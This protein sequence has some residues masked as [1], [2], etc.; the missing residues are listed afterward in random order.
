MLICFR[1]W[2]NW[3]QH[4]VDKDDNNA[5]GRVAGYY[6]VFTEGKGSA[7][8]ELERKQS[9]PWEKKNRTVALFTSIKYIYCTT[10]HKISVGPVYRQCNL[11]NFFQVSFLQKIICTVQWHTGSF[12][13]SPD[14]FANLRTL[15]LH[16]LHYRRDLR[17][18][19]SL[20]QVRVNSIT[21]SWSMPCTS[22]NIKG[23]RVVEAQLCIN[24][25]KSSWQE[26]LASLL[27]QICQTWHNS[28]FTTV[29]LSCHLLTLDTASKL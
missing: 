1:S 17:A 12:F 22:E 7:D 23:M 28:N 21:M 19:N 13:C 15:H 25:R 9:T 27:W 26:S 8:F 10:R 14:F 4:T 6:L 18:E 29:F 20:I 24:G 2:R 11:P 5:P 3:V 16:P